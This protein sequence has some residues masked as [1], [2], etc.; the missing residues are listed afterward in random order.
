[1]KNFAAPSLFTL[2][3][4]CAC[5]L[6]VAGIGSLTL[7]EFS[8]DTEQVLQGLLSTR[9]D[10]IHFIIYELRLPRFILALLTGTA[11]GL[12][13]AIVQSITRNP[14]SSPSLIGVSSGAAFAIVLCIVMFNLSNL[15][16]LIF[17]TLGGFLAA[18]LTFFIARKTH[19]SPIHLTLAGMSISLFFAA[20]ITLLLVASNSDAA[21]VYYWLAGSLA[22]RTWQHIELLF[23]FVGTGVTMAIALAKPLDILLLDESSAHS[24]GIAIGKWRLYFAVLVVI[25]TAATVAVAGPIAFVGLVAPH[26]VRFYHNLA[27]TR[28]G[29]TRQLPHRILLPLSGLVGATLVSCADLLAK[30]Q[31]VPVG[32]LCILLGGPIFVLLIRKQQ[33]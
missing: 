22:N 20:G 14:L 6:V 23:P 15:A 1:M 21:G 19:F 10:D 17:G 30:Y 13:G 26:F 25:L 4:F 32:I 8:L 11:L 9:D 29:T 7:G 5:T 18:T 16:T 2:T 3:V 24:L 33:L 27:F 31:E 12:A 28:D